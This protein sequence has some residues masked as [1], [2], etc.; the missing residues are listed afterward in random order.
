MLMKNEA[1]EMV[2]REM[3]SVEFNELYCE[4]QITYMDVNFDS[5]IEMLEYNEAFHIIEQ[6]NNYSP[7]N[8]FDVVYIT[9]DKMFALVLEQY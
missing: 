9:D 3:D 8:A 7:Y 1:V 6:L 5:I 2:V 4:E